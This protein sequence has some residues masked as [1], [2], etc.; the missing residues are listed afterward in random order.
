[1]LPCPGNNEVNDGRA[2]YSPNWTERG[3]FAFCEECYHRFIKKTPLSIHMRSDGEF[4]GCTCTCDFTSS[5]KKQWSL[6]VKKND[7]NIFNEHVKRTLKQYRINE[8]K[9]L[10]DTETLRY[11]TLLAERQM[12]WNSS[13]IEVISEFGSEAQEEY[14]FNGSYYNTMGD[15]EAAKTEIKMEKSQSKLKNYNRE[16]RQLEYELSCSD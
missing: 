14:Y 11:S 15:V 10:I 7:I 5:V 4:E 1:M 3:E 9:V 6:A 13:S 16:L 2:W 12:H 8:L